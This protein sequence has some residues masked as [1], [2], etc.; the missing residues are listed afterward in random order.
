MAIE[1]P[2]PYN[3]IVDDDYTEDIYINI[4]NYGEF[5]C[6][7]IAR[8]VKYSGKNVITYLIVEPKDIKG[9]EEGSV[10][11]VK[12]VNDKKGIHYSF[13]N[14]RWSRIIMGWYFEEIEDSSDEGIE[15]E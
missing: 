13:A 4:D 11:V 9:L 10:Y 5:K 15:E 7:K 14:R 12:I 1:L 2:Y 8:F 6:E 3:R